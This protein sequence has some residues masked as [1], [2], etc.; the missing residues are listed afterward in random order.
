LRGLQTG[1]QLEVNEVMTRGFSGK[2]IAAL[3]L[4]TVVGPVVVSAA[5]HVP[6]LEGTGGAVPLSMVRTVETPAAEV[7]APPAHFLIQPLPADAVPVSLISVNTKESA[8]FDLPR[9][10][11]VRADQAAEIAFFFRCRRTGRQMEIASGTLAVLADI[12]QRWP[13][14]TIEVVSG[15]RAPPF[16]MP[17]SKHFQGHAIDLRVVGVRAASVR[18][19]VWRT[20]HEVG[21]GHYTTEDFVH[22]DYRPGERDMAWTAH[23]EDSV[24]Q[25]NPGWAY[26]AR[27]PKPARRHPATQPLASGESAARTL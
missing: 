16:G 1:T 17:H 6:G 19:Y 2:R 20:H 14:R 13:G 23:G 15:F 9:N 5:K 26:K 21:V 4:A 25:Y 24:Y 7:A 27:H 12:A 11:V 22:I 3:A 8:R 18:D 10:G